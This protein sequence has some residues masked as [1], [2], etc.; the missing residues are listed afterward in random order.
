MTH[1]I[2]F[3]DSLGMGGAERLMVPYLQQLQK[4][5]VHLRVCA[6][7][8]KQ[9]NPI[10]QQITALGV[11]VDLIPIPHLRD[12]TAIPR[13]YSYLRRQPAQL[14]HTQLEF[15]NTIGTVA[16]RLHRLPT[17]CTLHTIDE[18]HPNTKEARRLRLM[19]WVLRHGCQHLIAVSEGLRQHYLA[20]LP[21]SKQPF[22]TLYNGI[23]I[24][25]FSPQPAS[26]R[27]THRQTYRLP[28]NARVILTVAVLRQPKGVQY[29]I[30]ALP[31]IL[32][33]LPDVYYLVVGSGDYEPELKKLA[34][35]GGVSERVIF[36]GTQYNIPDWLAMSDLFVLP[37][38]DDALPT[39]LMEAMASGL[40]II[41]SE[42]GGVPEMVISEENGL[43]L[44]P[45]QP[46]RLAQACIQLLQEPALA[47]KMGETG[48]TIAQK[49]FNLVRQ[50]DALEQIYHTLLEK[51]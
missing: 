43:L 36:A 1:I 18:L 9:G 34:E 31:Q 42:V 5:D 11:P 45:A 7:Q 21:L 22:T 47:Q 3:I 12:G 27:L 46:N 19:W 29:M 17:V 48:R 37:T 41:A 25:R 28:A 35:E 20:R 33:A 49:R 6:F 14:V 15:A 32:Q 50:A 10:A 24:E 2:W 44:P 8:I 23:D 30:Q 16:A 38:L 39:V 51:R 13:L 40:P 4:K 26:Q